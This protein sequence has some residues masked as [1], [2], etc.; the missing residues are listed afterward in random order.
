MTVA[1]RLAS[2]HDLPRILE[3]ERACFG[4]DAWDERLFRAYLAR[5]PLFF[6]VATARRRTVG[7]A[8][9]CRTGRRGEVE[10]I[11]VEPQRARRGI[12]TMLLRSVIDALVADG[13][14]S[15]GLVVEADNAAAIALYRSLGF[16]RTRTLRNYYGRHRDGWRMRLNLTE[17]RP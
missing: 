7:Y 4:G 16:V 14:A 10:S 15:V 5:C 8:I 17:P 12:G 6:L 13:A 1:L 11:A 9:G 2:E 3:I